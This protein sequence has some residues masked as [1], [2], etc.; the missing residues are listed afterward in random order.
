M[1]KSFVLRP[2]GFFVRFLR[3]LYNFLLNLTIYSIIGSKFMQSNRWHGSDI[4]P[5]SS[6]THFLPDIW[7]SYSGCAICRATILFYFAGFPRSLPLWLYQSVVSLPM[8]DI[9]LTFGLV[10]VFRFYGR[11]LD[12]ILFLISKAISCLRFNFWEAPSQEQVWDVLF[13]KQVECQIFLSMNCASIFVCP[14]SRSS[15]FWI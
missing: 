9:S 2:I 8:W 10:P 11:C 6:T 7:A 3:F 13:L 14:F 12:L 5:L 1:V 15:P 4:F